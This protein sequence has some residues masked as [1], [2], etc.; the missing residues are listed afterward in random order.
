MMHLE[1]RT[2]S[3]A[4]SLIWRVIGVVLLGVIA[5]L[6]TG[7]WEQ[8]TLITLIF[9]GLRVVLYYSHERIWDRVAW[10]RNLPLGDLMLTRPLTPE[11]RQAVEAL[12][13]Q[14]GCLGA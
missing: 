12:L 13:R 6:V 8:M 3:W 2:R 5:Y 9:H 11:D 10:G 7:N 4:K 1:T 14:R